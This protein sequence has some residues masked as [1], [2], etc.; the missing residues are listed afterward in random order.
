VV[1]ERSDDTTGWSASKIRPRRASQTGWH[2]FGVQSRCGPTPV[3]SLRSIT[4]YLICNAFGI[5][6]FVFPRFRFVG[7][8][9]TL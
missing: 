8:G 5:Q 3:M 4:G 7:N 2:T 6:T 9:Q 1:E